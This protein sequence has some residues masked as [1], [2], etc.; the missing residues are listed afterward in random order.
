MMR[1]L[2]WLGCVDVSAPFMARSSVRAMQAKCAA[3]RRIKA[4]CSP[5]FAVDVDATS[6][7]FLSSKSAKIDRK[8]SSVDILPLY[9]VK[10]TKG[11]RISLSITVGQAIVFE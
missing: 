5:C 9:S 1:G 3:K 4:A 10:L 2:K 11:G 8:E 6:S 7:K